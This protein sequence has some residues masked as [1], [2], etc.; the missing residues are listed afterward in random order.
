[1]NPFLDRLKELEARYLYMILAGIIVLVAVADFG[2][3][4]C[5]Q[6]EWI[7]VLDDKIVQMNKDITDL[8]TN[9]QRLAQFNVQLDLARLAR[10]NFNAMVH[11]KEEVPVVLNSISRIA[12]EFGVKIDQLAPQ[13]VSAAPLV[14]N[15]DG[16]YYTMNIA[17][18]VRSGFH[19]FGRFINRM[20]RERLFWQLEDFTIATDAKDIQRQDVKMN[21]KILISEK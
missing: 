1:M 3:V 9:R 14:Q 10:K 16:K 20:E 8:A 4:M 13:A 7:G 5:R 18:R 12:N 6:L 15:D 11:R 19:A 17:V 21:I 2:L